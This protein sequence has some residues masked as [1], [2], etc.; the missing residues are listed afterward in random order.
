MK[1]MTDIVLKQRLIEAEREIEKWRGI[2]FISLICLAGMLMGIILV[3]F[4]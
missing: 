4:G 1:T 3:L 2:A